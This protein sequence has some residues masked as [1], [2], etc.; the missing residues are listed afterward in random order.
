[1]KVHIEDVRMSS[2]HVRSQSRARGANEPHHPADYR[3][4]TIHLCKLP[5]GAAF[6]YLVVVQTLEVAAAD[7]RRQ[8]LNVAGR[9][10]ADVANPDPERLNWRE[11]ALTG[12]G[13]GRTGVRAIAGASSPRMSSSETY[14]LKDIAQ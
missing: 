2:T 1:M 11:S 8:R 6:L 7:S 4:S 3:V 14:S 9:R 10:L 5:K 12:A 13:S